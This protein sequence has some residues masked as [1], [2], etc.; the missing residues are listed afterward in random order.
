MSLKYICQILYKIPAYS[1]LLNAGEL[2]MC[3]LISFKSICNSFAL[4]QQI[5]N[6]QNLVL[7]KTIGDWLMIVFECYISTVLLSLLEKE[8]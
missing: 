2:A 1:P 7:L 6:Y 8:G 3:L 4:Q 5:P